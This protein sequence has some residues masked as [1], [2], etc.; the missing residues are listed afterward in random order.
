VKRTVLQKTASVPLGIFPIFS[1]SVFL[2]IH[3]KYEPIADT[4]QTLF[5]PQR[6]IISKTL[7]YTQHSRNF[8]IKFRD[9]HLI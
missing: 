5:W 2:R 3:F 1:L 7:I 9:I 8:G 4:Q 6:L